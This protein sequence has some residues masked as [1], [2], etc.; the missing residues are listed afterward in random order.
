MLGSLCNTKAGYFIESIAARTAPP[1]DLGVDING[2][3]K[4]LVAFCVVDIDDLP[5]RQHQHGMER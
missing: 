3:S 5:R 1:Y 2:L 4:G